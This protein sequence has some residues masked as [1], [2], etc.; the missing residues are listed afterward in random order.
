M[1]R[2]PIALPLLQ[3]WKLGQKSAHLGI[4]IRFCLMNI[5]G[6]NLMKSSYINFKYYAGQ[7]MCILSLP[8]K[9]TCLALQE[10]R[11]ELVRHYLNAELV[12]GREK[13]ARL[14]KTILPSVTTSDLMEVAHRYTTSSSCVIKAAS[15]RKYASMLALCAIWIQQWTCPFPCR[16]VLVNQG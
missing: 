3:L 2:Q 15:A 10:L 12:V 11:D 8:Q 14:T 13:E 1:C 5:P 16:H 6:Q 4:F 9:E 7:V